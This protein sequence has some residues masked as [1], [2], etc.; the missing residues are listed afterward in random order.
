LVMMSAQGLV[1]AVDAF[2]RESMPGNN[3]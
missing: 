3:R 2:S 1:Q